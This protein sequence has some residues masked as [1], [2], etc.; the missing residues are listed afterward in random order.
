MMKIEARKTVEITVRRE[1][2]L[3]PLSH[4]RLAM[5]SRTL[6]IYTLHDVTDKR[7]NRTPLLP[8]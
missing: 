5:R 6:Y 1:A 2:Q 8:P 7:F 4:L 3:L